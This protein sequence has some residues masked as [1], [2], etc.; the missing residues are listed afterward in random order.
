[1]NR[2]SILLGAAAGAGLTSPGGAQSARKVQTLSAVLSNGLSL[3][4]RPNDSAELVAIVCLVRASLAEERENQA[5]IAALTAES[6]VRGSMA[7]T[8]ESFGGAVLRVGAGVSALPGYDHCEFTLVTSRDRFEQALKLMAELL[9]QPRFA[10]KDVADTRDRLKKRAETLGEDFTG[11]SY[12]TLVHE[13]YPDHPYGRLMTGYPESLDPL[14]AD[15][16]RTFWQRYYVQNRMFLGIV[17]D[18]QPAAAIDLTQKAFRDAPFRRG[19]EAPRAPSARLK[20]PRVQL[21]T[22]NGPM[23]QIMAGFLAPPANRKDY[24]VY[25]LLDAIIGG[26]K[27]SRLFTDLREKQ[28]LGYEMG[29]LYQPL[30]QQSHL[31]GYVLTPAF[32]RQP[33]SDVL[34][35]LIEPVKEQLLKQ[36]R[37]LAA[38]G[39]TD[40]E[41]QR[42]RSYV[43]GK[44]ALKLERMRDQA[45]A[46]AWNGAMGLGND[47][48][49]YFAQR[50]AATTKD[51]IQAAAKGLV[52]EYA[53][54]VT[55]PPPTP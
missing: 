19:D 43:V 54:V 18:V 7:H 44:Q 46:L 11:A 2:R 22:R 34:T 30:R 12:Q 45:R 55:V 42:A 32:K 1:M 4:C 17:G 6:L 29:S 48:D 51:E 27:R 37:D 23:A 41:L 14:T 40:A 38:A 36:Y 33:S 25:T 9:T 10:A 20:G 28:G 21:L 24:A 53:L 5:G 16:V 39:P 13:L 26:G 8:Q 31:A 47:F 15:D 3:W 50:V 52:G 49:S 35:G